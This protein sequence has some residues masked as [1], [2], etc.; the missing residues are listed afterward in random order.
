MRGIGEIVSVLIVV[1]VAVTVSITASM[2]L[3]FTVRQ[4][5]PKGSVPVIHSIRVTGV[6]RD[7]SRLLVELV[8]TVQG[9]SAISYQGINVV[10][11]STNAKFDCRTSD[12]DN[13]LG[14]MINPGHTV[15]IS[16]LCPYSAGNKAYTPIL[17]EMFYVDLSQGLV[18]RRV[19]VSSTILPAR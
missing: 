2:I 9:S 4:S 16:V 15:T 10:D 12:N 3:I 7:Y 17:V 19:A 6:A 18:L 14:S 11:P 13:M 1:A 5:E 8:V